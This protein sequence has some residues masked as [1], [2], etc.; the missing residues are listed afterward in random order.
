MH[1]GLRTKFDAVVVGAGPAGS[2]AAILLARAGWAVALVERQRFPRRK[3]CGECIAASNLPLLEGL[4]IADE[5]EACAGP[6]LRQ[7][8]LMRADRVVTA[9]LPAADHER[10]SWGRALGRET[11]D[12]LL[13]DRARAAGAEV[14]QPWSV[15]AI[16]GTPGAWHCEVRAVESAALLRLHA[17]VVIDAH[18]SWEDLPSGRSQRRLARGAADLFAFKANYTGSSLREGAIAVLALDGGYGGM[19]VAASGMT[20]VACCIRRDRLSELRGAAPGLRAGDAVEAWLQR[21]CGGV[22]QALHGASRDG[23]WLASGPLDPG[24]RLGPKDEL[25]RIGNAA[26]EAH[27]ILG[28]GMSMGL[29]SAALLCSHLLRDPPE[30]QAQAPYAG[31]QHRYVADWHRQFTPRLRLAAA[32]A[33]AAMR[34]HSAAALMSLVRTWPGLLT[35]GAR[36]GGKVRLPGQ[37]RAA[38]TAQAVESGLASPMASQV[39]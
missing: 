37:A 5:F 19:V 1:A 3:V 8:M 23:S 20:T 14:F 4:G 29:Q 31:L 38:A 28:E 35:R 7:V 33:H 10:H 12:T 17:S 32:F 15:Q 6:E 21:E 11:L 30:V 25:F 34:P 16:L 2:T 24:V 13:L 27:P 18:G 36:W 22:R 9:D 39:L 26:G